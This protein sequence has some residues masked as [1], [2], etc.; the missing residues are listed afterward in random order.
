MKALI[1]AAGEGTR[2]RPLTSSMPKPLLPVAGRPFLEHT[3]M[4][5]KEAG[6]DDITIL[7]GW[8]QSHVVRHFGDGSALG[9]SIDYLKQERRSGTAHAISMAAGKFR[10]TFI[11]LNGDVHVTPGMIS[12]LKE[13]HAK[14]EQNVMSLAEVPN[15]ENFGIIVLQ[16]ERVVDIVEKP[17]RPLSNLANAGIY[18]FTPE[19]FDA[20]KETPLST[21]GEYEITD[22]LKIL[23]GEGKV[24]GRVLRQRWL[25]MGRPWDL[26]T[27]N[28]LI[29]KDMEGKEPGEAGTREKDSGNPGKTRT[30]DISPGADIESNVVLR[31]SVTVHAGAVIRSGSYIEGPVI[32]GPGAE[33]G[34]NAYIRGCSY[35]CENTK[36][37]AA[38]EV[39]NSIL[40]KGAK[41]PHH[42]YVG[43][44]IIGE[45]CN[46]GSGTK[47]ANLR[48]DGRNI[49]AV[50][51][52]RRVDTGRRKLGAILG[53][54]VKTGINSVLDCGTII[55][56]NSFI[57]PGARVHGTI[58]PGSRIL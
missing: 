3:I 11:C 13:L 38:S 20:I 8:Q 52:G 44:T 10:E 17:F 28:E 15:P 33:I 2:M 47:I 4:A 45:N 42:N 7:L 54:N 36:V 49:W 5:L 50:V 9:V 40:M 46:L 25:D 31:G 21:R 6:T 23:T 39:K 48:L 27:V 37:G 19:I 1:L 30:N 34:P 22:S 16:G 12:G 53:N 29:M 18:I 35:L 51:K 14:T 26:L 57:G 58:G 55:G 32:I 43:D 24:F 41:V 56:E